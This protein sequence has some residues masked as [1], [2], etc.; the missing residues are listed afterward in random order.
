MSL[1]NENQKLIYEINIDNNEF[2]CLSSIESAL[3]Y[4]ETEIV[5]L[6]E[7]I[8]SINGLRP[9]CDKI[10]YALAASSGVLC[11][12][13]DI[14][15][16]R[17]PGESPL[18]KITDKWYD[19]RTKGF[20]KLCGWKDKGKDA[21]ASKA[22]AIDF[23]GRKFK[24]PYDQRGAGDAGSS[25]FDLT[26]T[27][28]HFKSLA[29]NPS[30]LGLFFSIVDQFANTSHF[31]SNGEL[32]SLQ[33]ADN[34]F[35]LRGSDAPSK[36]FCAFVNWFGHMMSDRAG[37]PSSAGR[38]MGIPS[39]LWT[40]TNDVIA[41]KTK[42]GITPNDF[43][44]SINEVALELYKKGYDSRFQTAQAVP[45][46]INELLVR[47][48]YSVRR[49]LR[50][51]KETT[52]DL[53][54]FKSMW[55][56]CEAFKNP[57]VKRMLTVAH[58]T[59]CVIDAGEATIRAFIAGGGYFNPVEFFMRLNIVGVG[60]FT[61]SLFGEIKRSVHIHNVEQAVM[62]ARKEK[63]I[64]I[65][66]IESLK[67]LSELY[68]DSEL[69]SFVDDLKKGDLYRVAFEKTVSL[70][71]LREVPNSIIVKNKTEIDA[72]FMGEKK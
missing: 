13:I 70:A 3:S 56:S 41:I 51:F 9:E 57:T 19:E 64:V 7:T 50:Y 47:V 10:D 5:T 45:V 54:S 8:E 62:F 44:R 20:A 33:K 38:G 43:D 24:I 72:Y 63:I 34:T 68:N 40:W 32:I 67:Q 30:L 11:S 39:P 49:L 59:F 14:F 36:I 12:I 37:S 2:S 60:R 61:I 52:K 15:L 58:G 23:L 55:N 48:I 66:Y 25:I 16:V 22:S 1:T 42:L 26:P 71:E 35:E 6:N 28:H 17:K 31:V 4:A 46:L 21:K 27:N 69:L 29:H 65:D 53:R 18:G